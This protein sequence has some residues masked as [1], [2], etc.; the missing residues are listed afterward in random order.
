MIETTSFTLAQCHNTM[1]DIFVY[2]VY[3]VSR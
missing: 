2:I 1:R 3:K